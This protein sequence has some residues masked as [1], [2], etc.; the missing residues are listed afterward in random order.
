MVTTSTSDGEIV[1]I[2]GPNGP[3]TSTFTPPASCSV[4][5]YIQGC[6]SGLGRYTCGGVLYPQTR[7]GEPVSDCY[8]SGIDVPDDYSGPGWTDLADR[9]SYSPAF[10]CPL[11]WTT[12]GYFPSSSVIWGDPDSDGSLTELFEAGVIC[13]PSYVLC[14]VLVPMFYSWSFR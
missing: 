8:P 6:S 7:C 4:A 10:Y 2:G 1:S 11:G 13:C 12:G 5:F 9:Q 3:L 14:P